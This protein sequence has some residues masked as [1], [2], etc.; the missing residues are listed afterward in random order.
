MGGF[1]IQSRH[2][3]KG[4]FEL[5]PPMSHGGGLFHAWRNNDAGMGWSGPTLIPARPRYQGSSLIQG[6]YGTPGNLECVAI[7]EAGNLDFF[8]RMDRSPWTWSGPFR[9]ASGLRG[10]PS[11]IQSRHGTKGNFEVVAPHGAGGLAHLWRNNDAGMS[12]SA[13]GRFGGGGRYVGAALIQGNY[14]SPGN[15]ECVAVD[16]AGNLDFFWR[17]DRSPWTW[18]GP[19]RVA[20]G[21]RGA[22]SLIQ[23]RHGTKGNFEVVVPHSG[24]GLAHLWRNNDAGMTWSAPSRFGGGGQYVAATVF[25]GNY[26]S[27]GNLECAAIDTAGNVDF[28]WRMDRAPWTW[29]GPVRIGNERRWDLRECVY[30]SAV[31]FHQADT[32]V[33]L[34]IQLNPDAGISD[35]TM[36]TLRDRWR[37]GILDKWSSRFDCVGQNG[38]R[39]RITFDVAWVTSNAHQVVRVRPG[40]ARSNVTTWDTDDSGDVASHEFGHMIGHPDEYADAACPARNPVNTGSVMDD[41]TETLQRHY[42]GLAAFNCGHRPEPTR[43][44]AGGIASSVIGRIRVR[45]MDEMAP[46]DRSQVLRRLRAQV[47]PEAGGDGEV[48]VS[49]EVTGGAPGER[50]EYRIAVHGDGST[51]RQSVDELRGVE[52]VSAQRVVDPQLSARVFAA[53]EE[54]GLLDDRAPVFS[55]TVVPPDTIVGIVTVRAGDAVRRVIVPVADPADEQAAGEGDM[56][57][58]L[59]TEIRVTRRAAALSPLLDALAAAERSLGD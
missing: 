52:R 2:G 10:V 6:N 32:H 21:V 22:P 20:S 18:S 45:G 9:V 47:S 33:S 16:E 57:I 49:F 42:D 29:S 12:W 59:R 54:S 34:R 41:N 14:G 3:I 26:G 51:E 25:Q 31:A 13:P 36:A 15:L 37:T 46:E 19:F 11:L 30:G 35:A 24:G 5:V 48:E 53:A 27:P 38:T 56:E 17:M 8:W 4:N 1:M 55:D 58:P 50:L 7:D 39:K 43:L 23:S 40:P 28:F 44:V